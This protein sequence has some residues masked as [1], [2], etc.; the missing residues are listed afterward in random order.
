M[1]SAEF[2]VSRLARAAQASH[3]LG[4]SD[5]DLNAAKPALDQADLRDAAVLVLFLERSDGWHVVLT[6]RAS[7][8]RHHPGQIAFPGGKVDAHDA[9]FEA[10]ALREAKEEIG[11]DPARVEIVG[12][13]ANHQTVTNFNVAPVLGVATHAFDPV[14]EEGEVEVVFDVPFSHLIDP[15]KTR[16]EGRIWRGQRRQYYVIPFGPFYIWGATARMI[17]QLRQAWERAA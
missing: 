11:V 7:V 1:I 8:L 13:L 9:G 2:S 6:K 4:S 15:L 12:T 5:Y 3:D 14:P 10:A 16:I 17:V